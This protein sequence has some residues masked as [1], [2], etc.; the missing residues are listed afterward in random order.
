MCEV[1][2]GAG[3]YTALRQAKLVGAHERRGDQEA[4]GTHRSDTTELDD[5]LAKFEV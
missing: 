3:A 4:N 1:A 2:M 5:E